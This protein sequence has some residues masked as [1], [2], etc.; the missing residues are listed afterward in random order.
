MSE[1]PKILIVEDDELYIKVLSKY[2]CNEKYEVILARDGREGF[3]KAQEFHPDLIISDW[4]MPEM[5]GEEFCTMVKQDN[6][7]KWTYFM[8]L[9][10]K[11]KIEDLVAGMESGADDYLTKPFDPK[12]LKARVR[13]GLRIVALQ[14]ENN[15]LQ[16]VI[17]INQTAI[18]VNHEI[19]NPLMAISGSAD[20]VLNSGIPLPP[21]VQERMETIIRA[22]QRIREVTRKLEDMID[23]SV[24]QYLTEGETMIDLKKPKTLRDRL[25]LIVDD[26]SNILSILSKMI[27][28]LGYNVEKASDGEKALEL[29]KNKEFDLVISDINMSGM[30]G[31]NLLK[32]IKAE[33]STLP[34]I[35]TTGFDEE[36]VLPLVRTKVADGFI[37]KPFRMTELEKII[38][39]S[40]HE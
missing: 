31:M 1:S 25:I 40:F 15:R 29:L 19:N 12:E 8:I 33:T 27:K 21:D 39:H 4:L 7:L 18:T 35:L 37:Q 23:P 3:R 28:R 5:S 14:K 16:R 17:T 20:L 2:L 36:E 9:T 30:D 11:D 24:T 22:V 10:S 32:K 13:T 6:N 26:E 38:K 34:V